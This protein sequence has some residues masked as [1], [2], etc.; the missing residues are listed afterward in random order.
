M[1]PSFRISACTSDSPD[2]NKQRT[3]SHFSNRECIVAWLTD[4]FNVFEEFRAYNQEIQDHFSGTDQKYRY[5]V[6]QDDSNGFTW[7]ELP[8]SIKLNINF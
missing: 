8:Q 3:C 6:Q 7:M 5:Y 4:E 1:E 2:E